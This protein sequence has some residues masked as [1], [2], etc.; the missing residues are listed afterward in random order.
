MQIAFLA[1]LGSLSVASAA[2]QLTLRGP[3]LVQNSWRFPI[4]LLWY[5]DRDDRVPA[6]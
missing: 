5:F 6:Y 1:L 2:G 4:S 3:L